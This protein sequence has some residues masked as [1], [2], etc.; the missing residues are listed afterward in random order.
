MGD[1]DGYVYSM[2]ILDLRDY[3]RGVGN[4]SERLEGYRAALL[5]VGA[6]TTIQLP[7]WWNVELA[8]VVSERTRE[9]LQQL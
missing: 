8:E 1:Y 5:E 6:L 7:P 4:M 9:I 3:H 2:L